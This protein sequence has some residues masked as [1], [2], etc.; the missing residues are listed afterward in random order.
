MDGFLLQFLVFL[1]A[2]AVAAPLGRLCRVG[3]ILGYLFAGIVIS[4]SGLSAMLGDPEDLRHTAEL[5]IAMFLFL[6]GLELRPRRLIAMRNAIFGA[7]GMQVGVTIVVFTLIALYG[8]LGFGASLIVGLALSLSSTA[9]ALQTL[10]EKGEL[11]TRHGRLAFSILLFQDIAA[12]PMIAM[13]PFL[14]VSTLDTEISFVALLQGVLGFAGIVLAGRYVLNPVY[15]LIASTGVREAMTACALLTIIAIV[16]VM[17]LIGLSASLGAFLAGI[18]L[19]DSEFRHQIESDIAP[20]E[21]LLL[22]LFFITVGMSLNVDMLVTETGV[23]FSAVA[24]ITLIKI[25]ILYAVGRWQDLSDRAARRMALV[26]S[27]GG[28][29]GFVLLAA[30]ASGAVIDQN[31]AGSIAVAITISMALTPLLLLADDIITARLKKKA[32]PRFDVLPKVEAHVVIAGFGRFGQIV[33]RVLRATKI[34]FTA[35]DI[36][37]EQVNLVNQFGNKI[38]YGDASRLGILEAARTQDA[39]AFVLAIDDVET[40]IRT[41]QVVRTHFPHVPIYAR[42]RN[43]QHV[44]RLMDLGVEQI[45]RET[46]LGSLELT[47][48]L[49]KGLGTP[50]GRAKWII[51]MFKESDERRL[52]DDYKHYTD[53]EKVQLYARRQSQE[54]TELFTQDVAEDE[55]KPEPAAAK[56]TGTIPKPAKA[57]GGPV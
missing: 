29:F 50:D 43:R 11:T 38:Y 7:G 1:A 27:Q 25:A 49:L 31:L 10:D 8:G 5:G 3:S 23:I 56:K 47:S 4:A 52:Y 37:S 36:N 54:L 22:G 53:I 13:V 24:I 48:D 2:A 55:T 26:L 33:A 32:E 18:L 45:E 9:L 14:A 41:A 39:R 57:V 19:A 6:I 15:R 16:Y 42:A 28:E 40:S 35:L 20:F 46:F 51:E 21:G 17:D 44:H 30:A 12:I 34:P